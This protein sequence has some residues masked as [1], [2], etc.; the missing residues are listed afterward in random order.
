MRYPKQKKN[1]LRYF[2]IGTS[3]R[4]LSILFGI[5][6]MLLSEVLLINNKSNLFLVAGVSAKNI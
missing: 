4:F 6:A 1:T 2:L 5:L 3:F